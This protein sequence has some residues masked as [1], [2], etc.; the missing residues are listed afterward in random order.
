MN[1]K[2]VD[3]LP[4]NASSDVCVEGWLQWEVINPSGL[5]VSGGEQHNLILDNGLDQMMIN[6]PFS[7]AEYVCVGTGLVGAGATNPPA[8]GNTA[9]AAEVARTNNNDGIATALQDLGNGVFRYTITRQFLPVQVQGLNLTEW[10]VSQSNAGNLTVRELFRDGSNNPITVSLGAGQTIRLTYTLE[11]K[12]ATVAAQPASFNI[13]GGLSNPYT[14]LWCPHRA[15]AGNASDSYYAAIAF[16]LSLGRFFAPAGAGAVAGVTYT[17]AILGDF[18]SVPATSNLNAATRTRSHQ[19]QIGTAAFNGTPM[20]WILGG[21]GSNF[22]VLGGNDVGFLFKFDAGK[23]I[24]K[25][26]LQTLTI[27]VFSISVTRS[28]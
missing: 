14:G 4:P 8:V 1:F 19:M 6:G 10:G 26:N 24:Q 27:D 20:A 15:S 18:A 9:L 25:T 21:I 28:P 13:A 22:G 23:E 3:R 17:S 7:I 12:L 2:S 16:P 11:A 5:V